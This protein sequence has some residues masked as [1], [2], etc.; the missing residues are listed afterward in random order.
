M[1]LGFIN[2]L[3]NWGFSSMLSFKASFGICS[4][5]STILISGEQLGGFGLCYRSLGCNQTLR[6]VLY[7][8]DGSSSDIDMA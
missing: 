6:Q 8:D 4:G 7:I 1:Q 3:G 5:S 2:V